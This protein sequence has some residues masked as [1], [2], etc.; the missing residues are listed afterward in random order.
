MPKGRQ[1]IVDLVDQ[2]KVFS[3]YAEILQNPNIK[4]TD[5]IFL[6]ISKELDFKMTPIAL[7]TS[8]KRKRHIFFENDV[9]L[10]EQETTGEIHTIQNTSCNSSDTDTS[11]KSKD[12]DFENST[13][14]DTVIFTYQMD[15]HDWKKIQPIYAYQKR[16]GTTT[17][18]KYRTMPKF[19]W[20]NLLKV[21]I[22]K[23]TKLPCTWTLKREK[24]VKN[25]IFVKGNCS[26][27][28]AHAKK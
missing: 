11:F 9:S 19:K 17:F 23:H 21:N 7:Y 28:T 22:Y 4:S 25:K 24:V 20:S 12:F 1:S 18:K 27:C 5:P 8:L 10:L 26:Q 6:T 14:N 16:T 2:Q 13:Q 15:M 3:K